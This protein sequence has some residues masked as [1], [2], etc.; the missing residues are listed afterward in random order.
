VL[1]NRRPKQRAERSRCL[2]EEVKSKRKAG[3]LQR[4]R[5]QIAL[6]VKIVA[7]K[8]KLVLPLRLSLKQR[9]EEGAKSEDRE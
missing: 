9:C 3:S 5:P 6:S 8:R 7:A 4:P 2:F 1:Q